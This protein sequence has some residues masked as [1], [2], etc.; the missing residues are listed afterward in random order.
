MSIK[1]EPDLQTKLDLTAQRLGKSAEEI[2]SEAIQAHLED[3]DA[4]ALAEEERAYQRLY[5]TL[6]AKYLQQYVAIHDGRL[7]D[8]DSSFEELFLRIQQQFEEGTVLIRRVT[9]HPVEE[10]YFRSPRLE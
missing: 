6:R 9:D 5:P 4:R 3:L 2:A 10:Y 8:S 1:L 7:I